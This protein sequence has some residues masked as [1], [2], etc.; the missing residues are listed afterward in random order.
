MRI[1]GIERHV[2][3][4]G[5][6]H[7]Q[8]GQIDVKRPRQL[9][10][11]EMPR[12]DPASAEHASEA[13]GAGVELGVRHLLI[14]ADD[15]N[16]IGPLARAWLEDRVKLAVAHPTSASALNDHRPIFGSKLSPT[17]PK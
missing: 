13:V 14:V 11:D 10:S 8:H 3:G 15:R 12:P 16:V 1:L 17:V 5:L 4:A 7:P 2:R 9:K 6:E